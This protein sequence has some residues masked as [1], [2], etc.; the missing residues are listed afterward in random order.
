MRASPTAAQAVAGFVDM[1]IEHVLDRGAGAPLR[2][3]RSKGGQRGRPQ[4]L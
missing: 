3:G 2:C 1:L 4:L